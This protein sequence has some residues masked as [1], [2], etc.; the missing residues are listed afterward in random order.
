MRPSG[1][2]CERSS[3]GAFCYGTSAS[4][5]VVSG[6]Y[7]GCDVGHGEEV[8]SCESGGMTSRPGGQ[9]IVATVGMSFDFSTSK[10]DS[11]CSTRPAC[12]F[13]KRAAI[14]G[15]GLS[16][17][18]TVKGTKVGW[19]EGCACSCWQRGAGEQDRKGGAFGGTFGGTKRPSSRLPTTSRGRMCDDDSEWFRR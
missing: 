10:R 14:I 5:S 2:D 15:L 12:P 11:C 1:G 4:D 7:R 8:A 13:W 17:A 9:K 6:V 18:S 3:R 16:L 19:L